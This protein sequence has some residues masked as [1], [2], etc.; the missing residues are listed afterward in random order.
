MLS[1]RFGIITYYWNS[2]I[3]FLN[4]KTYL[5]YLLLLGPTLYNI[6][7][8]IMISVKNVTYIQKHVQK[9]PFIINDYYQEWKFDYLILIL[10][11]FWCKIKVGNRLPYFP[12]FLSVYHQLL[13]FS[14]FISWFF[15]S[16]SSSSLQ[17]SLDLHLLL[18]PT[19]MASNTLSY[20]S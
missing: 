16:D 7:K 1:I 2:T 11:T 5:S 15:Y 17:V 8:S 20:P 14:P 3:N 9:Y 13:H 12:L 4:N 19:S 10:S 6:W 18:F